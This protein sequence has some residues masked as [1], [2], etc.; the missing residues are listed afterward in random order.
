MDFTENQQGT[1]TGPALPRSPE[2]PSNT[3]VSQ[4][5][6]VTVST[7][8]PVGNYIPFV[9]MIVDIDT[10]ACVRMP[11]YFQVNVVQGSDRSIYRVTSSLKK[12]SLSLVRGNFAT[13]ARLAMAIPQLKCAN[14]T[15]VA[16]DVR[17]KCTKLYTT[18]GQASLLRKTS[19]DELKNFSWSALSEELK[20]RAPV[21]L[22]VLQAAVNNYGNSTQKQLQRDLSVLQLLSFS[23]NE[24]SSCVLSS[25]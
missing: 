17:K 12:A 8:V 16:C 6:A 15:A 9:R 13:F 7:H 5:P 25:V 20:R 23:G 4:S 10:T 3:A 22:S 1:G 24:I 14:V 11:L 19:T 21:F 18:S 2:A